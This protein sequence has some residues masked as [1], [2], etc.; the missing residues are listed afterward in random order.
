MASDTGT[1][2]VAGAAI[3]LIAGGVGYYLYTK[4]KT[5]TTT[6]T[7]TT[8]TGGGLTLSPTINATDTNFELSRGLFGYTYSPS[9]FVLY[10]LGFTPNG[11]VVVSDNYSGTIYSGTADANG[12]F[13]TTVQLSSFKP[14]PG[15]S[16]ITGIDL[17]TGLK[18]AP[19]TLTFTTTTTT[20]STTTPQ[21][22]TNTTTFSYTS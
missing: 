5:T 15:S 1:A 19:V 10:G 20:T 12:D 16:T 22:A 21:I 9:S 8:T 11:G 7:S 18:S 13:N 14:A 6:T 17:S 4:S 3:I 2:V